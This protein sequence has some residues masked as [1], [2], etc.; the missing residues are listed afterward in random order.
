M[1][2]KHAKLERGAALLV[3]MVI[4]VLGVSWML[5]SALTSWLNPAATNPSRNG[6]VLG[7]AKAALLGYVA[8]EVMDISGANPE[9]NPGR[10]PCPE[11]RAYVGTANEGIAAGNCTLPAVGRLPWR[12]LGLD[13]LVDASGE[14]LWYV[15]SP[16]WAY[17]SGNLQI[18]FNTVGQITL[19]NAQGNPIASNL[20]ALIIAPGPPLSVQ[21]SPNCAAINQTRAL[22]TLPPPANWY[23]NYLECQNA[24]YL[25]ATTFAMAGPSGSFNDQVVQITANDVMRAIEGPIAQRIQT[26]IAPAINSVYTTANGW[27]NTQ[28]LYPFAAPFSSPSPEVDPPNDGSVGNY[29]GVLPIAQDAATEVTWLSVP[30]ISCTI[31]PPGGGV[32][33]GLCTV[34]STT[35]S[36]TVAGVGPPAPT[37]QL[38][39]YASKVGTGFRQ[40][41]GILSKVSDPGFSSRSIENTLQSNGTAMVVY[42]GV[43]PLGV[44]SLTIT[45]NAA[46][47]PI[48][49][50]DQAIAPNTSW[51][52]RNQWYKFTYYA[53]SQGFA[54]GGAGGCGPNP[55][56]PL[57]LTINN[58]A[59]PNDDKH[60]VLVFAGRALTTPAERVG[61][62]CS[63]SAAQTRPSGQLTSYFECE[64]ATVA[65]SVFEKRPAATS[66]FNDHAFAIAP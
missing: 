23:Q 26:Q 33:C 55:T 8:K 56:L 35:V 19:Q 53:V 61:A 30:P 1:V 58:D 52:I 49:S 18:N 21:A 60:A 5:A 22:S 51:F 47:D 14:P 48:T 62:A 28:P 50:S 2:R 27:T 66:A 11:L 24:T 6:E 13:K 42:Q 31:S 43:P 41:P 36:C 25:A 45:I 9:Q 54:P 3:L 59:V 15:V 37:L 57:C 29:E 7:Q 12:T 44:S 20:I 46:D 39:A 63:T 38:T 40:P 16:G 32:S 4:L 10:L 65:D 17:T 34:S 64:N